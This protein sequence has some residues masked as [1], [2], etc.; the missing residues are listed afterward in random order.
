MF[1]LNP[2][3]PSSSP[4]PTLREQIPQSGEGCLPGDH[5]FGALHFLMRLNVVTDIGDKN[6][7][8]LLDQQQPSA[9]GKSAKIS[10]IRKM[11]NEKSVKSGSDEMLAKF[12]LACAKVH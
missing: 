10:N 2:D 3:R 6:A 9:P 8:G 5:N 1:G 4:L 11:A 12:V 7:A